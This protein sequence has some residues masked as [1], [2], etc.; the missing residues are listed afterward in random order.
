LNFTAWLKEVVMNVFIGII[1]NSVLL[2]ISG[3]LF[4]SAAA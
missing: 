2:I 4:N 1:V 3:V